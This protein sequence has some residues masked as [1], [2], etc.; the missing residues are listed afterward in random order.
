MIAI[1][2]PDTTGTVFANTTVCAEFN[3]RTI[4]ALLM[5]LRTH[6]HAI[7]TALA[8]ALTNYCAVIAKHTGFAEAVAIAC[9]I[10]AHSAICTTIVIIAGRAISVA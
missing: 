5:T 3:G 9:T 10:K 8:T 2:A 6:F 1:F 4:T 7:F